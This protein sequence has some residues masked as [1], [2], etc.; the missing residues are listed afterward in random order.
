MPLVIP[1][2]QAELVGIYETGKKGNPDPDKVAKRTAAAYLKFVTPAIDAGGSP[3]LQMKGGD[4]GGA[5]ETEL[6]SIL[7]KANPSSA[8]TAQKIA[9]AF[10]NCMLTFQ[11]QWQKVINTNPGARLFSQDLTDLLSKPQTTS[12]A[13]AMKFGSAIGNFTGL[14]IVSGFIPGPAPTPYTGPLN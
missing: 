2:L 10:I 3:F 13:F 6:I 4:P 8:L 11:T 5:L 12:T 1:S 7:S 9:S 14:V